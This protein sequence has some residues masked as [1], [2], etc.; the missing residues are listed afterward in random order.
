[1]GLD[2]KVCRFCGEEK[3]LEAFNRD[4]TRSDG[5]RNRCRECDAQYF[6][7]H[8][9]DPMWRKNHIQRSKTRRQRLKNE[10]P[11]HLW[12]EDA[13]ANARQRA[14]RGHFLCDLDLD[15]VRSIVADTCP[16]L[17]FP[18]IYAQ[19]KLSDNS[20]TLDRKNPTLGYTKGN[21]A[22]ISHR[23]N[24]LKSDSTIEELQTLLNNL[25]QYMNSD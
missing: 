12:A 24:R 9:Q 2:R 8:Y 20:P 18:L 25:V 16:L 13:L 5:R 1:M 23:A 3:A 15:Y 11:E 19:P 22:V 14:K 6:Q 10:A 7:Q 21:V 17:G 4:S